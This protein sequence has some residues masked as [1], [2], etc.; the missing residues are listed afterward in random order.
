M[1][2]EIDGE[3]RRLFSPKIDAVHSKVRK[4]QASLATQ[5]VAELSRRIDDLETANESL[6]RD[7]AGLE[8]FLTE[9]GAVER[10]VWERWCSE[11]KEDAARLVAE[12]EAK[13]DELDRE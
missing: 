3:L 7:V 5:I 13:E 2:I 6:Y 12:I 1:K 9:Q 8:A 11:W 10:E 4:V